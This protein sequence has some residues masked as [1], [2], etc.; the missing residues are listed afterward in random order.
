MWTFKIQG[1]PK[2]FSIPRL[3]I[4]LSANHSQLIST[5]IPALKKKNFF[6]MQATFEFSI[7]KRK[8]TTKLHENGKESIANVAEANLQKSGEKPP[9]WSRRF[10]WKWRKLLPFS[11]WAQRRLKKSGESELVSRRQSDLQMGKA[12]HQGG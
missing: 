6:L 12:S 5:P 7:L 4:F 8:R 1:L 3:Q 11:E 9:C 2:R 10:F